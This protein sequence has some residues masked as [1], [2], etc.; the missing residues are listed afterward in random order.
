MYVALIAFDETTNTQTVAT[1]GFER[2]AVPAVTCRTVGFNGHVFR[3]IGL[4][5]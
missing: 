3:V 5:T 1:P 2:N 4:L